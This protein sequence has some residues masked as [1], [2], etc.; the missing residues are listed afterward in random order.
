MQRLPVDDLAGEAEQ[1]RFG[2][3]LATGITAIFVAIGWLTGS[4][5][6]GL[7]YCVAAARYGYRQ[8]A[9]ARRAPSQPARAEELSKL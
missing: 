7:S 1:V 3:A 8:G 6:F 2:R 5:W 4:V 9:R